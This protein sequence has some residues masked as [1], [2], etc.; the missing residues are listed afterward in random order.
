MATSVPV[1][2]NSNEEVILKKVSCIYYLIQFQKGQ[3]QV[4][5]LFDSN[6]KVNA[7][8]PTFAQKLGFHIWKTNVGI[9]KI[10]DSILK[11]L[12]MVIADLK[13]EDEISRSRV[14]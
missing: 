10:D 2:D 8:N 1:T 3:K 4:R 11:T 12:E 6:S 7:M 9:Q 5:A 14:F 13:I